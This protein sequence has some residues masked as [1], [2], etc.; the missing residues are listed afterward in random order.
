MSTNSVFPR[1]KIDKKFIKMVLD[2]FGFEILIDRG[3]KFPD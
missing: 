2:K 3:N 1:Y